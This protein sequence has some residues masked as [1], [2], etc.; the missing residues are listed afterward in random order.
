MSAQPRPLLASPDAEVSLVACALRQPDLL[1]ALDVSAQDFTLAAPRALWHAAR[2]LRDAGQPVD[3]VTALEALPPDDV[4]SMGGLEALRGI[5]SA[6]GTPDNAP[7]YARLIQDKALA[8][9]LLAALETA[10][11]QV[12][13]QPP[14]DVAA[15]VASRLDALVTGQ[16]RGGPE[17]AAV[18]IT[19]LLDTLA[20]QLRGEPRQVLST[21]FAD[22]D[23]Y[24]GGGLEP[25]QLLLIGARPGVGK[26]AFAAQLASH[27]AVVRNQ[28]ALF[29]SL[30]MPAQQILLRLA[31]A[32]S[33]VSLLRARSAT[34]S[35]DEMRRLEAGAMP[36][37]RS[38]LFVDYSPGLTVSQ[39]RARARKLKRDNG[40]QLGVVVVDYLQL[41]PDEAGTRPESR[42]LALAGISRA[43]KHLAGEIG[44]PVVALSQLSRQA[45]HRDRP[46]LSD[47]RDSGGLEADADCVVLLWR[48]D[49]PGNEHVAEAILAK[50]R[51]GPCGVIPL[52]WNGQTASFGNAARPGE[53]AF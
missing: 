37:A 3:V 16:D 2:R 19:A 31:S 52:H 28:P 49:S 14:Q 53:P 26:S 30:E 38:P 6:P 35:P 44:T 33:G 20:A 8:R 1:D 5:V 7:A 46:A 27:C 32:A 12:Y 22:L 24:L 41:I 9:R 45:T 11:G 21:G 47:L 43:L 48:D 51:S 42:H 10:Q 18:G 36:L 13:E 34:L 39:L 15:A 25:G 17:P 40:G 23:K 4:A 50:Q 29:A